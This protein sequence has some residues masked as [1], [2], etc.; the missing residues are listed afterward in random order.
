[1]VLI[2]RFRQIAQRSILLV[3]SNSERSMQ[4][5]KP[6]T[7]KAPERKAGL[8]SGWILCCLL[9]PYLVSSASHGILYANT[10]TLEGAFGV[11]LGPFK[12]SCNLHFAVASLQ[13]PVR[14]AVTQEGSTTAEQLHDSLAAR[15]TNEIFATQPA[16]SYHLALTGTARIDQDEVFQVAVKITGSPPP[17]TSAQNSAATKQPN[18][19][20]PNFGLLQTSI[21]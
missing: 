20:F 19:G 12:S 15:Q 10:V 6:R 2:W 8:V 17:P 14:V 16:S 11:L 21:F 3:L 1:M 4:L 7:P 13:Y 5:V 18:E 9:Q